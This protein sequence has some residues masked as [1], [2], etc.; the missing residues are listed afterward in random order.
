[1]A[2]MGKGPHQPA[3]RI[4]EIGNPIYY[5]TDKRAASAS[6]AT[7]AGREGGGRGAPAPWLR[8]SAVFYYSF[9][10]F[11]RVISPPAGG[12]GGSELSGR[13]R[14]EALAKGRGRTGASGGRVGGAQFPYTVEF[15]I[16][17]LLTSGLP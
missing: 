13:S 1:M 5:K 11:R 3:I 17:F 15:S 10:R 2:G 16:V 14:P 12:A 9:A 6:R 4:A 8:S 7:K